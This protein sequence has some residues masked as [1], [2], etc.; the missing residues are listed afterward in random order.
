MSHL[1][2]D[3]GSYSLKQLSGDYI[4]VGADYV[5]IDDWGFEERS[6][7]KRRSRSRSCWKP[8]RRIPWSKLSIRLPVPADW[9]GWRVPILY[10]TILT[11]VVLLINAG[12]LIGAAAAKKSSSIVTADALVLYAGS[13][14][15]SERL[16]IAVHLFIN[17]FSTMIFMTST[18]CIQVILAPSRED[19]DECHMK[20]HWL[21][22]GV[23]NYRNFFRI[24][25]KR[26]WLAGLLVV[27]SLLL[28]L[29][30]LIQQP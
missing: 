7:R 28:H 8:W 29:L 30:Y 12:I 25:Q 27:S 19:V 22:L 20:G 16:S 14:Q 4:D 9:P 26:G 10:G 2:V 1:K 21:H 18:A 6:S 15:T 24:P 23:I 17:I 11:F 3:D 13:C 5:N